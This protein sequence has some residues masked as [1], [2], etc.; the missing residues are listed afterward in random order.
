[1]F[2]LAGVVALIACL[3]FLYGKTKSIR[4]IKIH[5][6][7]VLITGCDTGFGH[8]LVQRLD[9]MGFT[10]FAGCLSDKSQGAETLKRICTKRVHILQL[11]VTKSEDILQARKTVQKGCAAPGLWAVVNNAGIDSFGDIEFC[12]L[13]MY[14]RVAEV[15][16]FGM[17]H[18]TKVFLP[19]VRKSKGRIVNVTSVKGVLSRPT[20]SVYGATK[21][22]A[23]NFSDCLRLE[24]RK[25]GVK[26]SIIEP[27]NFGGLTG[28]VKDQNLKRLMNEMEI[29]WEHAEDDVKQAYGRAHLEGQFTGLHKALETCSPT[30][31]PVIDA[32]E[33][34]LVN[35]RPS[36][37]YLVDGGRGLVDWYNLYARIHYY[38]P[39][40][41]MDFVLDT[42]WNRGIR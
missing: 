7:G 24:M 23:E 36:V 32:L 13:D 8:Q 25:F 14:R 35:E 15:N 3:F 38:L 41:W 18:V 11:D 2:V 29:M 1:M 21:F 16:L 30:M 6:Q 5:G 42:S 17:I 28:I 27:G 40:K 10:V 39:S 19:L 9:E 4:R 22:G 20:I 26:V 37:R 33:D 12:T 31:K 34:A